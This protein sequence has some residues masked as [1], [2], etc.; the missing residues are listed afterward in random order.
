MGLEPERS[1]ATYRSHRFQNRR[2]SGRA[3]SNSSSSCFATELA[4]EQPRITHRWAG[5]FGVTSDRL[6]LAGPVGGQDGLWVA[7]GYSGHG[8]VL[9]LAC[10]ELVAAAILGH[11]PPGLDLFDPWR[12]LG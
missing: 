1:R 6:P 8:N 11:R 12:M 7:C 9:G 5:T 2:R 3:D 10:G 4:A